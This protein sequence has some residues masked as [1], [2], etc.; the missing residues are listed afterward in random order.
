MF[1]GTLETILKF[2]L[3]NHQSKSGFTRQAWRWWSSWAT[4][5]ISILKK[6]WFDI[7]QHRY[8]I[9]KFNIAWEIGGLIFGKHR[10]YL[11][12]IHIDYGII[13]SATEWW[14]S[15]SLQRYIL[16]DLLDR[17]VVHSCGWLIDSYDG[18]FIWW[19]PNMSVPSHPC[20]VDQVG[21]SVMILWLARWLHGA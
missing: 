14:I 9:C 4:G 5:T 3:V 20:E 17:L 11:A 8:V 7:S 13:I 19:N 2:G 18:W 15:L 10:T 1:G 16:C 6:V 12:I 21:T